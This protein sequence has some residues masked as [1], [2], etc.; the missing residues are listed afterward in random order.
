MLRLTAD[1]CEKHDLR[2]LLRFEGCFTALA[3]SPRKTTA[4]KNSFDQISLNRAGQDSPEDC[5]ILV[6]MNSRPKPKRDGGNGDL[7][8][9]S[10]PLADGLALVP[11]TRMRRLA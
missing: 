11:M 5:T 7:N 10:Y 9:T 2:I 6:S 8:I 4:P 3:S 1:D